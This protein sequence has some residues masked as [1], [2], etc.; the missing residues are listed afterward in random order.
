MFHAI[1]IIDIDECA[2][3][4][5]NCSDRM[6]CKNTMGG[7]ECRCKEGYNFSMGFEEECQGIKI[8]DVRVYACKNYIP[9]VAIYFSEQALFA[10]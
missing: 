2:T 4:Q 7:Y 3:N 8:N 1:T 9:I 10:Q 6:D 5:H